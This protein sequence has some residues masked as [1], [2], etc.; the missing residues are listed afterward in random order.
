MARRG[1]SSLT[2]REVS[3]YRSVDSKGFPAP[4]VGRLLQ[5]KLSGVDELVRTAGITEESRP[6]PKEPHRVYDSTA[7]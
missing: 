7:P 2:A 3:V 4:R 6:R 5:F 1:S